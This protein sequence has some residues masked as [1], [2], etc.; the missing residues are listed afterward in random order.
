MKVAIATVQAPFV[1]GGAELHAE[2]LKKALIS[3]GHE[4]EVVT[5]PFMDSPISLI[6][7]HIIA[8]RLMNLEHSW[9]GP[10]D[11][12]IG[13]KFPAYYIPH[14]NKVI[15]ALHQHRGAYDLFDTSFTNLKND[16]DGR[17][18]RSAV[19]NADNIYFKEAKRLYANSQNVADRLKEYNNIDAKAL[20]HPC[21]DM[22]QFFDGPYSDYILMPSRINITKRQQLAVEALQYTKSGIKLYIMGR[23]DHP[24]EKEKLV[25]RVNELGLSNRV[26]FLEFVPQKE[27]IKL[28]ANAR[29][30]LFIPQDEDYGY[31]TLEG[32][33]ASKA[34]ITA[35]D[36]GGPLE[37]ILDGENGF[38]SEPEPLPLARAIDS[39]GYDK[40][41]AR[42]MGQKAKQRLKDMNIS[43]EY[44]V[45]ELTRV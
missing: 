12:C 30:V 10:I 3:A 39:L 16:K 33:A 23:A 36:S 5:M 40:N 22:E 14:P 45:K 42:L 2:N 11:L 9:A 24:H 1:S 15:W 28:Y 20:Y 19:K 6:E 26:K 32:M 37:F 38:I 13:L 8:A 18:I 44:V 43:W 27:K 29:G 31:I 7:N 41:V 17:H 21:P 35:A 34:V 25:Q 4:A